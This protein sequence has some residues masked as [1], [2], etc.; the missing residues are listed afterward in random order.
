[1]RW[2]TEEIAFGKGKIQQAAC[3]T[4]LTSHV[5]G[6]GLKQRVLNLE[7][8]CSSSVAGA[9]VDICTADEHVSCH[10]SVIAS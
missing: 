1:M 9:C 3:C 7:R 10:T 5:H 8:H 2:E 6:G 4:F